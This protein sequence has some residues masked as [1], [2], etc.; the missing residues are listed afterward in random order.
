MTRFLFAAI[1]WLALAGPCLAQQTERGREDEVRLAE[2]RAFHQWLSDCA[3][4]AFRIAKEGRTDEEALARVESLMASMERWN[5]I[6]AARALFE[7]ASAEPRPPAPRDA[8]ELVDFERELQ[9]WRVR[10][11]AAEHLRRMDGP[12]VLEF[13][14]GKLRA[15]GLRSPKAEAERRE[16][17]AALR[18]LGGHPSLEARLELLRA[19]GSL[20][21][22]LRVLAVSALADDAS[23]ETAPDLIEL[24]RDAE[25][26]VRIA[27]AAGLGRALAPHVDETL[28]ANPTGELLALRDRAIERLADLLIRDRVWQV[29]S[30]AASALAGLSCKSVVPALIAGL[31]AELARKRDPWAMDVRL[32]RLLEGLT[33]QS[34]ARGDIRPWEEFWRREGP[35]FAVKPRAS[36]WRPDPAAGRYRRFFGLEIESDRVLFVLDFSGSMAEPVTLRTGATAAAAGTTRTKADLVVSEIRRVALA[37]PDGA[38]INLVVFGDDVRVWREEGGR[39]A[40]VR[41]DDETRD[42]LAGRFLDSLRPRGLTNLHGALDKAFEFAGR[43]LYDK[44]YAAGFD[45]IYVITDGAPTAGAVTDKDEI[46]RLV[47][48]ANRLRRIAVH[49]VTFGDKNDTD[50]LR[51]LAE[52]NGGRHIHIE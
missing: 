2:I 15:R 12:G 6:D 35:S 45:T 27:A 28:G 13:L 23:L 39:P 19:C 49:C 14:T 50:F 3:R 32:H 8:A 11:M 26:N 34:V 29:R 22:D 51:L 1:P 46:R 37:M 18:V 30:A 33:G 4:G 20:P 17:R 21:A 42:D 44:N 10:R 48:E 31:K 43:S 25:P 24:L 41:L 38:G 5:T 52:E 40:L 47:R 7:A 16:A 36:A 9:P